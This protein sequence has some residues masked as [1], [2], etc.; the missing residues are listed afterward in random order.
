MEY[1]INEEKP[2][3][4]LVGKLSK[5]SID[6]KFIQH[7]CRD[8]FLTNRNTGEITTKTAFDF[9]SLTT[10]QK[11]SG[12]KFYVL[13][14]KDQNENN[15]NLNDN[16]NNDK[17]NN[18]IK[19]IS[20]T[21]KILDINDHIPK[22]QKS[23]LHITIDKEAK[24]GTSRRLINA[25]DLDE[26]SNALVTYSILNDR[27]NRFDLRTIHD[28][29]HLKLK[30]SLKSLKTLSY[31]LLNVS[32][33]DMHL[34]KCDY[35][36]VNLTVTHAKI[37]NPKF[38][39]DIYHAEVYENVSI[40]HVILTV[41]AALPERIYSSGIEYSMFNE[42][43]FSINPRTGE[44]YVRRKLDAESR[45][46]YN[47][48]VI[49]KYR[50]RSL[51]KAIAHVSVIVLDCN[52]NAPNVS[53]RYLRTREYNVVEGE[54]LDTKVAILSVRDND[55]DERNNRFTLK[56]LDSRGGYFGLR[57]EAPATYA[58]YV[59]K[60]IDRE[61]TPRFVLRVLASDNGNPSLHT[62]V[63][64]NLKVG[65]LNDNSPAFDTNDYK[66]AVNE[67]LK[68]GSKVTTVRARDAD[69]NENAKITYS[70]LYSSVQNWFSINPDSGVIM[71]K[72]K[73][74]RESALYV[75]LKVS[76]EDHGRPV[77][78]S[79]CY[80]NVTILDANDNDPVFEPSEVTFHITENNKVPYSLG[81]RCF[82]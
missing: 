67:S 80:V 46:S 56:L 48:V 22:F 55:K 23:I 10:A 15:N 34:Q 20:M 28:N 31:T 69:L 58:V 25:K 51:K 41:K 26:G 81:K 71:I 57:K 52:D 68:I 13:E 32:A 60:F 65:D 54:S 64:I 76:A 8:L 50:G 74:D 30:S 77:L 12:F 45:V 53:V 9:E 11:R 78:R 16:N 4:V 62:T 75:L 24:I 39:Q 47:I 36:L 70:I 27:S 33:C 7:A 63:K 59:K 1:A 2:V 35:L 21:V 29:L 66:V 37:N 3:G 38:E 42:D 6:S 5:T 82:L 14:E 43:A 18:V 73:L 72:N 40:G 17:L 61:L 19:N 44:V 49:A 79:T